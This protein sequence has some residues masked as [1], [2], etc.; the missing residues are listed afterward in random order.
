MNKQQR[1][2]RLP[3]RR[4]AAAGRAAPLQCN[5]A[6]LLRYIRCGHRELIIGS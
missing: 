3:R 1:R 5:A 4:A 6:A 2:S